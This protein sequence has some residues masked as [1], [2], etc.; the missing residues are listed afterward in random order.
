MDKVSS[1]KVAAVLKDA[2]AALRAQHARI[3][4]LEEK[5]ASHDRRDRASKVAT[6]MREK[7][8]ETDGSVESLISRL[9]KAAEENKLDVIEAAVDM[10][11]PNMGSKIAQLT[12]DNRK[13]S[14]GGS[15][16]ERYLMGEAG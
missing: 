11:G 12:D 16:L 2:A 1:E 10:Y 5:V 13:G 3:T 8:L 9:E 6:A 4:E 7:G 15:D 14:S